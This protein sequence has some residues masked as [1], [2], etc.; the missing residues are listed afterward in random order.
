M[1]NQNFVYKSRDVSNINSYISYYVIGLSFFLSPASNNIAK[2]KEVEEKNMT[3]QISKTII[4]YTIEQRY[5]T[6]IH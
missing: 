6:T 3:S 4:I 5:V 2:A 1:K